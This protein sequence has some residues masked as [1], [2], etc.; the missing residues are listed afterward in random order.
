MTQALGLAAALA[1]ETDRM[2]MPEIDISVADAVVEN[3]F[4]R[5]LELDSAHRWAQNN[6]GLHLHS[7]G[8]DEEVG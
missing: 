8:R 4:R 3:L 1:P 6:L 5:T 7:H 2:A